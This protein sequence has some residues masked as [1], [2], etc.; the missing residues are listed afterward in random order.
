MKDKII[1]YLFRLVLLV[2]VF[3]FAYVII[4]ITIP[5]IIGGIPYLIVIVFVISLFA[6]L[7]LPEYIYNKVEENV[8]RNN[9]RVYDNKTEE[10]VKLRNREYDSKRK[11]NT[12]YIILAILAA[13]LIIG[14]LA[15]R[16]TE[17]LA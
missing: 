13:M 9:D 5:V 1:Q 6:V 16:F 7:V 14:F 10:S 2:V 15:G 11:R 4:T 8:K 3:A 12:Q 17:V